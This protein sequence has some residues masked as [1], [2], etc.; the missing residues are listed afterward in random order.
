MR[1]KKE[2]DD[3]GKW[4]LFRSCKLK[5]QNFKLFFNSLGNMESQIPIFRLLK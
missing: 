3:A 2:S 4:K 1:P 5:I